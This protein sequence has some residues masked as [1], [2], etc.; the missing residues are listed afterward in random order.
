METKLVCL[1]Q[2]NM[3]VNIV[4]ASDDIQNDKDNLIKSYGYAD[5]I[6]LNE[7][8]ACEIGNLYE[9]NIYVDSPE[10]TKAKEEAL[11]LFYENELN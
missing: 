9:N 11:K 3:V 4:I 6:V 10:Q 8:V 1:N 5:I 7:N 2:N